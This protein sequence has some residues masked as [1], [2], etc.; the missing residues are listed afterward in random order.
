MLSSAHPKYPPALFWI[1][2]AGLLSA[3]ALTF[4]SYLQ[5]CSQAC[6]DGHSYRIWGFTF[7]FVG[8]TMFPLAAILHFLSWR[9]PFLRSLTGWMLC[10]MLGGEVMMIYLQK[11]RI[12]SWCPVC[13]AIAASLLVA[14][15]SLLVGYYKDF[16]F[17]IEHSGRGPIMMNVYKG[18]TGIVFFVVG[19]LIAFAGIGKQNKLQAVENTVRDKISFGKANSNIEV[20][21][22][23]DWACPA[24]RSIE[25]RIE[26]F[27]PRIM[28]VA[29]LTFVDDPIHPE[30]LNYTP[31]NVAFMINNK[32]EYFGLRKSL[33]DLSEKT[34][35]PTDEQVQ[36]VAAKH[37]IKYK[38]LN[39]SE[40]A[41][42]NKYFTSL[43]KQMKVEGT[44]TV[45]VLNKTTQQGKK[46][47][48]VSKITEDNILKTINTLSKETKKKGD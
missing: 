22:F 15:I 20:F 5:L 48:G 7:E 9:H 40:V 38:Q 6:N 46:L 14:A 4:I 26:D 13:L 44:P 12:G 45:V 10:A 8:L 19:F 36:A 32:P 28:E 24:C 34:K 37:G 1:T 17:T 29:R 16:K 2:A 30:S 41:L 21:I 31:Y 43:V 35:E 23:T 39:Y 11:Y 18:L 47:S 42:A 33:Q 3:C 25:G 27:A